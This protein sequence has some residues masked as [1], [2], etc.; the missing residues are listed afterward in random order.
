VC[1][2][3]SSIDLM[4]HSLHRNSP[5]YGLLTDAFFPHFEQ[6]LK[7]GRSGSVDLTFHM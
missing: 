6:V 1:L 7:H 5:E 3:L 4:K 2:T